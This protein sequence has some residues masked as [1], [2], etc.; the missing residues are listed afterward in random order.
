LIHRDLKP[1]NIL[2]DDGHN[3]KI[4]DFSSSQIYE[5]DVTLTQQPGAPPFPPSYLIGAGTPLYMAPE[6]PEGHYDSKVD[7]YSFGLM[8]YEIVV[9]SEELSGCRNDR[10]PKLLFDLT[11]GIRPGIPEGTAAFAKTLIERCWAMDPR[12]RPSFGEIWNCLNANG[13]EILA[14]VDLVAVQ[15]YITMIEECLTRSSE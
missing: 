15:A 8:L 5:V 1:A 11:A 6:V 3:V 12:D 4:F 13:F 7:V 2:L 9:G 14:G 10:K